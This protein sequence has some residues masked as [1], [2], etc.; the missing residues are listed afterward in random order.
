MVVGTA[1]ATV[2]LL[3]FRRPAGQS[4][5]RGTVAPLPTRWER[6]R[7]ETERAGLTDEHNPGTVAA[8]S[9]ASSRKRLISHDGLV[10]ELADT[11]D[12]KS[13]V[14]KGVGV[15]VSPRLK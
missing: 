9:T 11:A 6:R 13:A 2:A 12:S 8:I 10:V 7:L 14:R 1:R 3:N 5:L 4:H 15:R